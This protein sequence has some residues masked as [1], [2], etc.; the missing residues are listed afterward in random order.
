MRYIVILIAVAVVAIV[1]CSQ[2]ERE[3]AVPPAPPPA[4]AVPPQ[5]AVAPVPSPVPEAKAEIPARQSSQEQAEA[6]ARGEVVE[7]A[8]RAKLEAERAASLEALRQ[9]AETRAARDD[10]GRMQAEA[11][12]PA[13]AER[14][15]EMPRHPERQIRS[16]AQRPV[17]APLPDFPWP[18][19]APSTQIV[20]PNSLFQASGKPTP[21]LSSVGAQLVGAL[22]QAR[23]FEYSYYRVPNGFA[24]VARL[25]RIG[26]DG[27]PLPEEFRFLLPGS[28][29]PFSLGVYI[30]QLFFAPEGF[31]RQIVIVVT[32]RPFT[33]TGETLDA[34]A[35]ARLLSGGA[36]RLSNDFETMRF[37]EAHR[38][39]ALIYE[40]KKGAQQGDVST[41]TPGR[42]GARTHLERAGIY[43]GL[44]PRR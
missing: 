27:T 13:E 5:A 30:K 22:E 20:L 39:S 35:A 9:Q 14:R 17:E 3:H 31:Y 36:N 38:V 19:P 7:R 16:E 12:R 21:S 18:P 37:T 44:A 1:G 29:E 15:S 6:R 25:E 4:T 26:P 32:D 42:L 23:Y 10:A 43:Q 41:L 40:F 28:Q 33:A 11:Q 8:E 34:P 24:L 2:R